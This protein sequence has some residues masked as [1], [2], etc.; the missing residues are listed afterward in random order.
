MTMLQ[1]INNTNISEL[2]NHVKRTWAITDAMELSDFLNPIKEA[3]VE[4]HHAQTEEQIVD[5]VI[6]E[7][8]KESTGLCDSKR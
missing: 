2:Y 4:V 1:A 7:F 8:I 5:E 6:Q 3:E